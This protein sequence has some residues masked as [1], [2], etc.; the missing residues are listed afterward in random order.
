MSRQAGR[1]VSRSEWSPAE[2]L[3]LDAD[4][5]IAI[6]IKRQLPTRLWTT[7]VNR[8]P[9]ASSL[10]GSRVWR[11]SWS[12][13]RADFGSC[14]QVNYGVASVAITLLDIKLL[15]TQKDRA[16]R[17][18]FYFGVLLYALAFALWNL[19]NHGCQSLV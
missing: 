19:D 9:R 18:L 12:H 8:L 5:S 7:L 10:N 17:R 14:V 3:Q 13:R 2:S 16:V 6:T 1:L 15:R 4:I 11:T